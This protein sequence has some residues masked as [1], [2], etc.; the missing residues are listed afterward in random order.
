[1]QIIIGLAYYP[2]A[3]TLSI[4]LFLKSAILDFF[5]KVLFLFV[6]G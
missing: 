3:N 1:M 5:S 6:N 4:I 2:Q